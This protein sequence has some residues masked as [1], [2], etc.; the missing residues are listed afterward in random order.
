LFVATASAALSLELAGCTAGGGPQLGDFKVS[1]APVE[2]PG[3]PYVSED[4]HRGAP[5]ALAMAM[6]AA[7]LKVA[8]ESM[9]EEIQ[10]G[11][12]RDNTRDAVVQAVLARG[13]MPSRIHSHTVDLDMVKELRAGHAVMVLLYRG[14]LIRHWE[15]ALVVGVDPGANT[16]TLNTGTQRGEVLAYPELLDAWSQGDY[17]SLVVTRPG[18]VPAT[19]GMDEWLMRATALAAAGKQQ[20]AEQAYAAA[21]KRWPAEPRSWAG[22]GHMRLALRDLPGATEALQASVR[23]APNAPAVHADL[24]HVL[25]E[26]QCADQAEDEIGL[27]VSQEQDAGRRAA[28]QKYQRQLSLHA[29]PSVVCPLD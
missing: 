16:F 14:A 23:L 20:E 22:L 27:A 3:V 4:G 6:G 9:D 2:V 1:G 21:T 24:A 12:D 28:Y 25:S 15:Y 29:G 26:R 8:A 17:W 13:I 5:A 10:R 18:D 7:G 19:A 11:E